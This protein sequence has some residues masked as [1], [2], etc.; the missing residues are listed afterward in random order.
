[1]KLLTKDFD[2]ILT[3]TKSRRN[4]WFNMVSCDENGQAKILIENHKKAINRRQD[5]PEAYDITTVAYACKTNYILTSDHLWQGRIGAVKVPFERAI[6]I[7]YQIDLDIA[8]FLSK[9][10]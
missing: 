2:L 1:M 10:N 6:D 9:K 8:D 4:P 3:V 5:A 7:D